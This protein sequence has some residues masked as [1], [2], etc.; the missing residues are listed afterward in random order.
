MDPIESF[1]QNSSVILRIALNVELELEEFIF[2]YLFDK[3]NNKIQIFKDLILPSLNFDRKRKIFG[4]ICIF[5]EIKKE[6]CTRILGEIDFVKN[7]RNQIAHYLSEHI[8]ETD[9][10]IL[11]RRPSLLKNNKD[12]V[13]RVTDKLVKDIGE[14]YISIRLH[15]NEIQNELIEKRRFLSKPLADY[16]LGRKIKD[17]DKDWIQKKLEKLK[18]IEDILLDLN[19]TINNGSSIMNVEEMELL[20]KLVERL[21]GE[22]AFILESFSDF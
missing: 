17:I 2:Q 14:K 18:T 22:E 3:K 4:D 8:E 9:E 20:S 10:F 1:N 11:R 15:L 13:L 19:Q 5:E 21:Q 12:E 16:Y 6:E 7:T